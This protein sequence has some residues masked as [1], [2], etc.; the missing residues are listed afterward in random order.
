MAYLTNDDNLEIARGN[1]DRLSVVNIFGSNT[2][3]ADGAEEDIW[4]G[5]GTY[6]FP[7]TALITSLSQTADQAALRGGTIEVQGLDADWN[8]VVQNKNLDLT[9]TTNVVT[10]DTPL[11]RVFR[12][13]VLENVVS[14]SPIRV[15]NAGETVDYAIINTGDN[16]TLM[17][18]YTVPNGKTAY[19]T[20]YF[21]DYGRDIVKDPYSIDFRLMASDRL[22]GYAFQIKHKKG[23]PKQA[24]GFQHDFKPYNK[25]T[26]RT[27]IKMSS[28]ADGAAAH[29]HG[30]F[31]IILEG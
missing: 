10:L 28:I 24:S 27:D 29:V 5:G 20:H 15:H 14:A 12:A 11:I 2:S 13:R 25:F 30:G 18:I 6:S 1:I 7:A 19:M 22:N 21:C 26:E 9:L 23:L 17:A 4:N 16:Q 31:D 3:S 8:Q